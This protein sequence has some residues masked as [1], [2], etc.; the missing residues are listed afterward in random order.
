MREK[1]GGRGMREKEGGRGMREKKDTQMRE[2]LVT[3][4][5]GKGEG[6]GG[7]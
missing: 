7:H 2:G 5:G 4:P 3:E 6:T 1:E